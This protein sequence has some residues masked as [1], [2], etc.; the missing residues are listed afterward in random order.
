MGNVKKDKALSNK[1]DK[2]AEANEVLKQ[3]ADLLLDESVEAKVET[4]YH[5]VNKNNDIV[6]T[7]E[8]GIPT[9]LGAQMHMGNQNINANR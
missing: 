9:K 4:T 2:S 7:S 8:P 6:L 5:T 3:I 1:K